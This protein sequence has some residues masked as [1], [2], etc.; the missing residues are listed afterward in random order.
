MSTLERR[1]GRPTPKAAPPERNRHDT[2]QPVPTVQP[3]G[4]KIEVTA[5]RES[6]TRAKSHYAG[7]WSEIA[8]QIEN[9]A[10]TCVGYPDWQAMWQAEYADLQLTADRRLRPVLARLK[11]QQGWPQQQIADALGAS[12]GTINSDLKFSSEN[13]TEAPT[14]IA[15]SRGQERPASYKRPA[16]QEP[17]QCV[18]CQRIVTK[19]DW[20]VIEDGET[21]CE[22]CVT[23]CGAPAQPKKQPRR[24]PWP[25]AA[26]HAAYRLEK[27]TTTIRNLF[28]DDRYPRHRDSPAAKRLL[29]T[30]KDLTTLMHDIEVG[31]DRG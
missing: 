11:R 1:E 10:W 14:K 24:N 22:D 15:N 4:D 31:D 16:D 20:V 12:V 27:V 21:V 29:N 7:F 13:E 6:I 2:D 25:D 26:D 3:A 18:R 30:M 8:W 9:E 19:P 23:P 28:E 17:A 5:V